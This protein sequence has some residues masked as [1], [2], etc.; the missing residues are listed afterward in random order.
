MFL[1]TEKEARQ[2]SAFFAAGVQNGWG[3]NAYKD[4]ERFVYSD[5]RVN[6]GGQYNKTTGEYRCEKTGIYY[7]TY[8]VYGTRIE[9]GGSHSRIYVGLMK[10]SVWQ[11]EVWFSNHNT[12]PIYSSLSQSLVLQCNAGEKV[13][14]QCRGDNNYIE[15][16]S[17]RNTFAGVLLFMN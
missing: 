4:G 1:S 8:S 9:D 10:D 2:A 11:G 3:D 13:W 12:E 5:I 6:P 16:D 7:F 17:G 14:V 15:G